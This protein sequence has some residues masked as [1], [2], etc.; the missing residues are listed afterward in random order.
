MPIPNGKIGKAIIDK[1]I[2]IEEWENDYALCT[3]ELRRISKYT[4]LN[5]DEVLNLPYSLYLLYRKDSWIDSWR[6]TEEGREFLKALWR[7]K[8]TKADTKKIREFQ[9]RKETN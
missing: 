2:K 5:F 3:A 4:G 8:Q 7:L 1:Y 6:K 9:Q